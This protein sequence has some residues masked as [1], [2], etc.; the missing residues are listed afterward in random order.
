MD[1]LSSL[2]L[3]VRLVIGPLVSPVVVLAF[4]IQG[5]LHFVILDTP[6]RGFPPIPDTL[7]LI[8]AIGSLVGVPFVYLLPTLKAQSMAHQW[9]VPRNTFILSRPFARFLCSGVLGI[10]VGG[11]IVAPFVTI[12]LAPLIVAHLVMAAAM[13][14]AMHRR[15]RSHACTEWT[16]PPPGYQLFM[17][18]IR[19]SRPDA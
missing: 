3:C 12:A 8:A 19:G 13:V 7:P 9:R 16:M 14:T 6:P 11:M 17:P 5:A 1:A 15:F 18:L 10:A 4:A 2:V